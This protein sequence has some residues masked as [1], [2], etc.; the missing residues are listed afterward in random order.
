MVLMPPALPRIPLR[1]RTMQVERAVRGVSARA[2]A[3]AAAILVNVL[4][5][6]IL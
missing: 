3:L 1:R 4:V 2:D 5:R 6:T